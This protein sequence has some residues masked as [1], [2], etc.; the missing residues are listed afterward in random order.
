MQE[1]GR[2]GAPD[3]P[4]TVYLA[5]EYIHLERPLDLLPSLKQNKITRLKKKLNISKLSL[6]FQGF[7]LDDQEIVT[8]LGFFSGGGIRVPPLFILYI[9]SFLEIL[10]Y[11]LSTS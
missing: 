6:Y 4:V 2:N 8:Y 10:E 11:L 9:F 3:N 1:T 7:K 5:K